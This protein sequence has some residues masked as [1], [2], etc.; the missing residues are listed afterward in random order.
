LGLPPAA[1]PLNRGMRGLHGAVVANIAPYLSDL[2]VALGA[3]FDDRVVGVRPEDFAPHA[4]LIHVDVDA[5]QLNRVKQVDLAIHSDVK[6]ALARLLALSADLPHVDRTAWRA[7]LAAIRAE[8]PNASYDSPQTQTLT[9]EFVYGETRAAIEEGAH[10]GG[11]ARGEAHGAMG[12]EAGTA[13][14]VVATFDVGTHQMKGAQWFPVSQPR[15]FITSGGMGSM[16]CSLPMAVGAAYARPDATVVAAVGDGGLVP[17]L[18]TSPVVF[19][20]FLRWFNLL[21]SPDALISD[22]AVI[23]DVMA[24]Y[25]TRDSRP[26]QPA[27]GPTRDELLAILA[28]SG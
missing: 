11:T 23:S 21:A 20:A 17:A 14:D 25:A 15:S 13:Q 5:R 22:G 1:D 28:R 24:A 26:P 2:T 19:R 4:K 6:H 8:M 3:R 10:A 16:A 18:Q 9:H 27:F 12:A 7:D